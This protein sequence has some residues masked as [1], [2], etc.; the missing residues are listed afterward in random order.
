MYAQQ[1]FVARRGEDRSVAFRFSEVNTYAGCVM[2]VP[3][4]EERPRGQ[5]R[6]TRREKPVNTVIGVAIGTVVGNV[7]G[8]VVGTAIRIL[9]DAAVGA[10][11]GAMP[12]RCRKGQDTSVAAL[13]DE[14][15]AF[16]HCDEGAV[17]RDLVGD[18]ELIGPFEFRSL[19]G[20]LYPVDLHALYDRIDREE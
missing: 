14:Q 9:V 4:S 17:S 10:A 20:I 6:I 5:G 2:C 8:A 15:S 13:Y 1:R 19:E 3:E 12:L 16:F 7:A 18:R 11:Y